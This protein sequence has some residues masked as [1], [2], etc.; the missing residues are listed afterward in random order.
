MGALRSELSD[1]VKAGLAEEATGGLMAQ[2]NSVLPAGGA[3]AA[4]I[5]TSVGG[6]LLV[7]TMANGKPVLRI[8]DLPQL[9]SAHVEEVMRGPAA[10]D[11]QG[12][13]LG[14]FAIQSLPDPDERSRRFGEWLGAIESIGPDLWQLIGGPLH[15]ALAAQGIKPGARLLWMP[16]GALGLLPMGLAKD[17]AAGHP[18]GEI[19]EMI[20]VPSLEALASA[21]RQVATTA[22]KSL[23]AVINPT[24]DLPFTET[25]GALVAGHFPASDRASL[26]KSQATPEA[27]LQTLRGRSY[28]H[29]SSHGTFCWS[30]ARQSGLIMAGAA[31]T[32]HCGLDI[33]GAPLTVGRLLEGE[34]A[35]GRPR[36]VVLS[37]CE[38]GI[39]DIDRNPD[40]FVGL[41]ATFMQLGAAGVLGTLWQVDDMATALLIAKFYDVHLRQ[42]ERPRD[43]AETRAG[44]AA[45]CHGRRTRRLRQSRGRT[46]QGR[47]GTARRAGERP[48]VAS[49]PR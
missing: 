32:R 44:L 40:E 29:F 39:Y 43:G 19:Y 34:S 14:A 21:G 3:L 45:Q 25:E 2:L 16:P 11:R 13:W 18:L 20:N 23:A 15:K 33:R 26:D 49:P 46:R 7:A 47:T 24:G 22:R 42:G 6:K 12:G 30:D 35:L 27:V 41:P 10:A 17:G 5:V 31:A 48:D 1:L 28:W 38:T 36:L 4:P 8:V 9:T 37:A